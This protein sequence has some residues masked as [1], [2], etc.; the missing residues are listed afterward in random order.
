MA[1]R[2]LAEL[3]RSR[4]HR[5]WLVAGRI[6]V[7]LC[8]TQAIASAQTTDPTSRGSSAAYREDQILVQPKS[9]TSAAALARFHDA[10][11]GKVLR[12]FE[13]IGHLQIVSVA[14]GET[15]PGLVAKYQ[16][17]GLVEFA[18]PD[19]I[20]H[21]MAIPNEQN[22]TNGTLWGLNMIEA[23]AA[24]DVLTCASNILVAVL[25]TGVRYTHEDLASNMWTNPNGGGH[26]LNAL[27]GS[28]DPS[29]DSGHGTEVAGVLGAVGN[30]GKGVVGVAWRAQI[31]A[32]KC[33]NNFG[34]GTLSA[35][36]ACLD[37][38][39]TNGARIVNASWGFAP[40]SLAL[41]NAVACLRDAGIIV[42][43]ACGNSA[44]DVDVNPVYPACYPLDNVVSVAYTTRADTLATA[45]NY[46]RTN[47]HLAA[48]GEQIYSTF[49]AA[50]SGSFAYH[51]DTGTSFA[52]PYVTGVFALML[53]G[54]PGENYRQIINRVLSATEPLPS[55]TGKCTTGGRLNVR[56]ALTPIRLTVTASAGGGPFQL[57]VSAATNLACVIQVSTDLAGWSP[58]FT[59]ATSAS[60]IFDFIDPQSTNSAL[61][62]YRATTSP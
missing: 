17:S 5:A 38:A 37:Y 45:S 20:G 8:L 54:Y 7:C 29:D 59:N 18:E 3:F 60:G 10:Q 19:Y 44:S 43:A 12:I 48:P 13:K 58:I 6:S 51:T 39:R 25:D 35:C 30:N 36:I 14:P 61:R 40:G 15:V 24:W 1:L 53:V 28:N 46:G 50:D 49:G 11:K 32:C 9:G 4:R 41:S 26:G 34:V 21:V 16:Q 2:F 56:K 62:F 31:M 27:T 23:P 22:Y 52:A 55:L 33:F 57:R 42:V 47:V